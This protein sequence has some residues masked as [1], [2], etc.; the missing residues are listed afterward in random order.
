MKLKITF[1]I[2]TGLVLMNLIWCTCLLNQNREYRLWKS[3]YEQ[4]LN[5]MNLA[6]HSL[7]R[8]WYHSLSSNDLILPERLVA[9]LGSLP[10]LVLVVSDK[11][12]DS[13][14]ETC[15]LTLKKNLFAFSQNQVIILYSRS[16]TP[17]SLWKLRSQIIPGIAFLEIEPNGAGIPMDTI[18]KPYFFVAGDDMKISVPFASDASIEDHIDQYLKI[19]AQQFQALP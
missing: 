7:Q 19:I 9:V 12:C 16:S 3:S 1:V 14:I 6:Y 15:I 4:N 2:I 11:H 8:N 13:C 10:K 18:M 17:E 5:S